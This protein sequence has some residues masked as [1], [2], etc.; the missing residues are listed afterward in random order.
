MSKRHWMA[1]VAVAAL[2]TAGCDSDAGD[3]AAV[4]PAKAGQRAVPTDGR[5]PAGLLAVV[6]DA[7]REHRVLVVIDPATGKRIWSQAEADDEDTGLDPAEPMT[8]AVRAKDWYTPRW[9][10]GRYHSKDW[11]L[12]A[13]MGDGVVTVKARRGGR[14]EDETS[15]KV[16]DLPKNWYIVGWFDHGTGRVVANAVPRDVDD[17]SERWYSADPARPGEQPRHET[18]AVGDPHQLG[19]A[20]TKDGV[21]VQWAISPD[22]RLADG[23]IGGGDDP[24][25][26]CGARPGATTVW[27][28]A[29]FADTRPVHG[30]VV[31][32]SV[33]PA[34]HTATL[35]PVLA[36]PPPGGLIGAFA[37]PDGGKLL[38]WT[39]NGWRTAPADGSAPPVPAFTEVEGIT[40]TTF[41]WPLAWI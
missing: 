40:P 31:A 18:T 9:G 1:G 24:P 19:K 10:Y 11:D 2:L 17:D 12:K 38:L 26:E 28:V 39:G 25:Y 8:P 35:R 33:D 22:A 7:R 21:V 4:P 13:A 36:E 23:G 5:P 34:R 41:L 20:T 6:A 14:W 29:D 3:P 16:P 15:W 27:C 30:A 32:V 37:S